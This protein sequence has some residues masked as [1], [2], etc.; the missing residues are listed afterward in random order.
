VPA[1]DPLPAEEPPVPSVVLDEPEP[2]VDPPAPSV[3]LVW[4]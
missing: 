4:A 2:E 3:E 1:P